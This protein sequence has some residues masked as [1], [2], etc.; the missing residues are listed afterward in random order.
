ME[1]DRQGGSGGRRAGGAGPG[2]QGLLVLV[3]PRVGPGAAGLERTGPNCGWSQLPAAPSLLSGQVLPPVCSEVGKS[4]RFRPQAGP[5]A[6]LGWGWW[7]VGVPAGPLLSHP[8]CASSSNCLRSL[9]W[10]PSSGPA[11]S[12]AGPTGLV[13]G[14][15]EQKGLTCGVAVQPLGPSGRL[16]SGQSLCGP[17]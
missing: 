15:G 12:L 7:W 11:V 1:R 8:C 14:L 16:E 5:S 3:G 4:L 6:C 17:G 13:E 10:G 9:S 2:H